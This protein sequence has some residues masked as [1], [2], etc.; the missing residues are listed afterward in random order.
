MVSNTSLLENGIK[1]ASEI[2][3]S[4]SFVLQEPYGRN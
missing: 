2:C 1:H 3:P 4:D